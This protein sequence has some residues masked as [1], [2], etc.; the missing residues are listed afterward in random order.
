MLQSSERHYLTVNQCAEL[1]GR[2]PSAIRNLCMRRKI[3]YR[4][5]GGRLVFLA[6]EIEQWIKDAEGVSLE[7]L[8][9]QH[10]CKGQ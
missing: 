9:K 5:P 8:N 10:R 1:L 4:K 2:S 7:Q 6:D 3:P